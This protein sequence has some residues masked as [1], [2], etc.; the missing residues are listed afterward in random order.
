MN[1]R[2]AVIYG[3]LDDVKEA[4]KTEKANQPGT[5]EQHLNTPIH[6]AAY[7]CFPEKLEVLLLSL[8]REERIK[9]LNQPNLHG[10]TP[11]MDALYPMEMRGSYEQ[12]HSR[13]ETEK[14]CLNYERRFSNMPKTIQMMFDYGANPNTPSKGKLYGSNSPKPG[15]HPLSLMEL[16]EMQMLCDENSLEY[17]TMGRCKEVIQTK[18]NQIAQEVLKAKALQ[19]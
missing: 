15:Q 7:N 1:L 5:V 8:C 10:F 17:K 11:L 18:Q 6:L 4:L 3:T 13:A 19:K 16:I 12:H 9:V 2:S 14:Y